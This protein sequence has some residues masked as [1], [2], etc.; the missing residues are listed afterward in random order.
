ME[1]GRGQRE[2]EIK[3]RK[4]WKIWGEQ[5]QNGKRDKVKRKGESRKRK[6]KREGK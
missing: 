1:E 6:K 2:K 5:E 3:E 4:N